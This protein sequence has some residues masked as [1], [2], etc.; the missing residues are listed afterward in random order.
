MYIM[1][2]LKG[3]NPRNLGRKEW[4]ISQAR[5]RFTELVRSAAREPQPIYNR[6]RLVG[7]VV[8]GE[9][10]EAFMRW[11]EEQTRPTLSSALDQLRQICEEEDYRLVLPDRVD[12]DNPFGRS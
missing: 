7:V 2:G 8:D 6:H 11:R 10:F 9:M 3:K 5:S 1:E 12:R 4:S